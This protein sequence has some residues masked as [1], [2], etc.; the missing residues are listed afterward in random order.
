MQVPVDSANAG[1]MHLLVKNETGQHEIEQ[2]VN[3]NFGDAKYMD[4]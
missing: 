1:R 3:L 2:D 4:A